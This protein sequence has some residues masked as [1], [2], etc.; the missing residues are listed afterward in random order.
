[1]SDQLSTMVFHKDTFDYQAENHYVFG[2]QEFTIIHILNGHILPYGASYSILFSGILLKT[3]ILEE[4]IRF[5]INILSFL[6]KHWL[7]PSFY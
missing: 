2:N 3:E 1:M 7:Y 6:Q 4:D 5:R